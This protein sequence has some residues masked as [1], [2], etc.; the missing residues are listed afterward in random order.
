[1]IYD[2]IEFSNSSNYICIIPD[3]TI[4]PSFSFSTLLTSLNFDRK[5]KSGRLTQFFGISSYNYGAVSHEPT[6]MHDNIFVR[7]LFDSVDRI[8][9]SFKLNSC[10]IN[11]YPSANCSMPDHSDNEPCIDDESFIVTISLGTKRR[12]VFKSIDSGDRL[13]SIM[14]YDG[15]VL[16]FSKKS[17]RF[18][19]HGI[20]ATMNTDIDDYSPRISAT[21]R[22]IL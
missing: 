2:T 1:V 5:F 19:T 14:L 13:C 16:I 15:H 17:Q 12:M 8:F 4:H 21:F 18:F 9:P 7:E 10:L 3:I 11:Y 6:N 22:C 20:P